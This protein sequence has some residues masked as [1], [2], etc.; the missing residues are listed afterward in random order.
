MAVVAAMVAAEKL[1]PWENATRFGVAAVLIGLA[2]RALV[3]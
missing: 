3:L 1:L 2:A